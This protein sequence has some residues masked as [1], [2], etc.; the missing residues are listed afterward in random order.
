MM[1]STGMSDDQGELGDGQWGSVMVRKG[2]SD[3]QDRDE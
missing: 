2:I 1:V 3:G